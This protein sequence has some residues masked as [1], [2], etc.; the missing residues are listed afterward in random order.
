MH[1]GKF[2]D[3]LVAGSR[4]EPDAYERVLRRMACELADGG[5]AELADGFFAA[6]GCLERLVAAVFLPV[7]CKYVRKDDTRREQ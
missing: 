4:L 5:T 2:V 7:R 3:G 6:G 1:P